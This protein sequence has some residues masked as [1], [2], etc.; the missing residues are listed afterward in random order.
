VAAIGKV[1]RRLRALSRHQARSS[2]AAI[3]PSCKR[4]T[5]YSKRKKT[6][7]LQV[8]RIMK[9]KHIGV[10]G[11]FG[12][13][14]HEIPLS[15]GG[16]TFIHGPNGCGKTTVLR[17][18]HALLTGE[19]QILKTVDF[20][21]L[22]ISYSDGQAVIVTRT[23]TPEPVASNLFEDEEALLRASVDLSVSLVNQKRKELHKFEYS[24]QLRKISRTDFPLPLSA[25]ERRLP[26]LSRT[27]PQQWLDSRSGQLFSLETI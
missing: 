4:K 23:S 17:L 14:D 21:E 7:N 9:I 3:Q 25:V 2:K 26:F 16:L 5:G 6:Q 24:K 1:Q 10:R 8:E 22:E 11:L 20:K 19:L 18:V 13:L 15:D 27:A 12:N